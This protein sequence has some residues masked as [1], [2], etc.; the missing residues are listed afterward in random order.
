[1]AL[2]RCASAWS[3]PASSCAAR[4]AIS[5]GPPSTP[6]LSSTS[7]R[8]VLDPL[9]HSA[10]AVGRRQADAHRDRHRSTTELGTTSG[11]GM[12]R[13]GH[14]SSYIEPFCAMDAL[15]GVK[16]ATAESGTS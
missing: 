4:T 3:K 12:D 15:S 14:W 13:S 5:T 16:I 6:R 8:K 1:M 2:R 9:Q 7:V 10:Q 11:I